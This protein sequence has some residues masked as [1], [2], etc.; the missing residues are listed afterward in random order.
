MHKCKLFQRKSSTQALVFIR[1]L[2]IIKLHQLSLFPSWL[3]KHLG[4][5]L[6]NH[7]KILYFWII[8]RNITLEFLLYHAYK[9]QLQNFRGVLTEGCSVHLSLWIFQNYPW[10]KP[11]YLP[12]S[13]HTSPWQDN[14]ITFINLYFDC[15]GVLAVSFLWSLLG[16]YRWVLCRTHHSMYPLWR[17]M[18]CLPRK[19]IALP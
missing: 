15:C 8:S 4:V 6:T 11:D 10:V 2:F 18:V 17:P 19:T 9:I 16:R 13:G 5:S 7:F 14:W 3:S 1:F 12:G